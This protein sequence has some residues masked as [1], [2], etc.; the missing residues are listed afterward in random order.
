HEL[1]KGMASVAKPLP[2]QRPINNLQQ[3]NRYCFVLRLLVAVDQSI[4]CYGFLRYGFLANGYVYWTTEWE[5]VHFNCFGIFPVN[6]DFIGM[7]ESEG[8]R[9]W[10]AIYEERVLVFFGSARFIQTNI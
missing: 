6:T 5:Y 10:N 3:L 2:F 8:L 4:F 7:K 9:N 1:K